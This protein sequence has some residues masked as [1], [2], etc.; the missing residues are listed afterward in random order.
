MSGA[1]V[2]FSS[3]G[4]CSLNIMNPNGDNLTC[5][6]TLKKNWFEVL[7]IKKKKLSLV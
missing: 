4:F 3:F 5:L 7:Y 1:F 6:V 2:K